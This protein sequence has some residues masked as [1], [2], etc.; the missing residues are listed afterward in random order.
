MEASETRESPSRESPPG[1]EGRV[2][3][4]GESRLRITSA[5]DR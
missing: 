1:V 4:I 3:L 5:V 2:V